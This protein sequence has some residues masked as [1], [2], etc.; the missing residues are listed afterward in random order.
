MRPAALHLSG[1]FGEGG[2]MTPEALI[3]EAEHLTKLCIKSLSCG[4]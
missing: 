2:R 1:P 4:R 3:A